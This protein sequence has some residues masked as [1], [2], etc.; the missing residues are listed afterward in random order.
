M[1]KICLVVSVLVVV[2]MLFA[3]TKVN[4]A[5]DPNLPPWGCFED[6]GYRVEIVPTDGNFPV[7]DPS[8]NSV[9]TYKFTRIDPSAKS[10]SH[11]DMLIH[12]C[13]PSLTMP[14]GSCSPGP[15]TSTLYDP[16]I[17]DSSTGF[18]LG[19]KL[20]NT[21][22]W[23]WSGII[24]GKV[25]LT[26][27]PPQQGE[28]KTQPVYASPN[29][30]LLK[31]GSNSSYYPYG[32]ILAPACALIPPSV[33]PPQVPQATLKEEQIGDFKVC[34]ES[35]DPSG[36]PTAMYSCSDPI[37]YPYPCDCPSTLRLS[38]NKKLFKDIGISL[39]ELRQVLTD[40][41]IRCPGSFLIT[42][43]HTC[44]KKCYK[45]GYCYE[46]GDTCTPTP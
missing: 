3:A 5:C 9:F 27:P 36:C 4:A 43:T 1:K 11:I 29:A 6:K 14:T 38:W 37:N 16:G 21:F 10:V 42:G 31:M 17:G 45:S 41:D 33:V 23:F 44:V 7:I 12:V 35:T 19:L 34:I 25:S 30:M 40:S 2:V 13:S 26:Y 20:E 24:T 15:C 28:V 39:G 18:G 8:G 46:F 32:Q 22:K